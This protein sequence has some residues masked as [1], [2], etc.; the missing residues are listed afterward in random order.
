MM[1][2]LIMYIVFGF[3]LLFILSC[4]FLPFYS[5]LGVVLQ[6]IVIVSWLVLDNNCLLT[7]CEYHFF[8]QTLPLFLGLGNNNKFRVPLIH[9]SIIYILFVYNIFNYNTKNFVNSLNANSVSL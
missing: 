1:E 4:I 9:R 6:Y 7:I 5:I 2:K 8:K 3:H